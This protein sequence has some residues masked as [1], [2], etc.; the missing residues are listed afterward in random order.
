MKKV[1][2]IIDNLLDNNRNNY[3]KK[4]IN[5]LKDEIEFSIISLNDQKINTNFTC[6]MFCFGQS[7]NQNSIT[8]KIKLKKF[9]KVN[10]IDI[11]ISFSKEGAKINNTYKNKC[12]NMQFVDS[13]FFDNYNGTSPNQ[14]TYLTKLLNKYDYIIPEFK[15]EQEYIT[16]DLQ[17]EN[18]K[19]KY[20]NKFFDIDNIKKQ[21]NEISGFNNNLHAMLYTQGELN[22]ESGIY[23]LIR[24]V[25]HLHDNKRPVE[26]IINGEGKDKEKF[27]QLIEQYSL[28][29]YVQII[30]AQNIYKYIKMSDVVCYMQASSYYSDIIIESLALSKP[31]VAVDTNYGPREIMRP[32]ISINRKVEN[33]EICTYGILTKPIEY[34]YYDLQQPLTLQEKS[35]AQ[36]LTYL[37]RDKK[38]YTSLQQNGKQKSEQHN[39]TSVKQQYLQLFNEDKI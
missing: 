15:R 18:H 28:R 39:Q 1:C 17:I 23:Q 8:K 3:I 32:D 10:N 36:A 2:I 37:L 19:I 31:V 12:T 33:I 30:N 5:L 13:K 11:A 24:I 7:N 26:L 20:F 9:K 6:N 34:K 21:S 35:Y 27:I 29:N 14:K 4:L 38:L 16:E 22:E 25:K